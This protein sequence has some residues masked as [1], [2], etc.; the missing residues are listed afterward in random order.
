[1]VFI[2]IAYN[3]NHLFVIIKTIFFGYVNGFFTNR[4][5]NNI[6]VMFI[7]DFDWFVII[8]DSLIIMIEHN[9]ISF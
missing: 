3:F 4:F 8:T 6:N 9:V 2:G 1:M 5:F 7:E